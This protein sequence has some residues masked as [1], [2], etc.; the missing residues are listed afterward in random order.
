[1]S[2]AKNLTS[3]CDCK[4]DSTPWLGV[5]ALAGLTTATA[6]LIARRLRHN[7]LVQTAEDLADACDSAVQALEKRMS[8]DFSLA[9]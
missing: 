5:I 6:L 4:R 8:S 3:S 9:G 2:K 1:M 7:A